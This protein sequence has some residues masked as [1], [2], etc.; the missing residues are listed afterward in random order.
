V[1]PAANDRTGRGRRVRCAHVPDKKQ[2]VLDVVAARGWGRIGEEEWKELRA[3]LPDVSET[4]IRRSGISIAQPWRGV[5]Q[6]TLEELDESLRE[7]SSIYE[8]R[9]DL[10]RYCR[11]QVIAAKDRARYLSRDRPLKA[12]MV[13]SM[14]VWLGDPAMFPAWAGL[15]R[16]SLRSGR[17]PQA[18]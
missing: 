7:L 6:H 8:Q 14:L 16:A 9:P 5:A 11:D 15:R 3:A 17:L 12:E 1:P 10:R 18:G 2:R 13:E 4:T